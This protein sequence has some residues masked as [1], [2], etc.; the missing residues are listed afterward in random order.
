M[1]AIRYLAREPTEERLLQGF[2]LLCEKC[3]PEMDIT[4]ATRQSV[5]T[6]LQ[7]FWL[8]PKWREACEENA[9]PFWYNFILAKLQLLIAKAR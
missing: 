2:K 5:I 7:K 6:Y 1:D 3:M 8:A 4:D 9:L